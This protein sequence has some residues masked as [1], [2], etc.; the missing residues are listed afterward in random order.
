MEIT[1]YGK[2]IN[3]GHKRV[4]D[5]AMGEVVKLSRAFGRVTVYCEESETSRTVKCDDVLTYLP[6]DSIVD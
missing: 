5:V 6:A 2:A 1:T 3:N 4:F